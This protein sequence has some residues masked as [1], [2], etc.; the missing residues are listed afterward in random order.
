MEVWIAFALGI[1]VGCCAALCIL[2]LF[3]GSKEVKRNDSTTMQ[4]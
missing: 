4:V 1:F 3:I 2:G